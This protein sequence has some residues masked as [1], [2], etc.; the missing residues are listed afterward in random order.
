MS[1]RPLGSRSH[2]TKRK[3]A[4]AL[5]QRSSRLLLSRSKHLAAKWFRRKG[6]TV[7]GTGC[8]ARG[9][10]ASLWCPKPRCTPFGATWTRISLFSAAANTHSGASLPAMRPLPT[11][12]QSGVL[13]A[14]YLLV[15]ARR[16]CRRRARAA[17]G[18]GPATQRSGG[19][20]PR[21]G[22]HAPVLLGGAI[23]KPLAQNLLRQ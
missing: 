20:F 6:A 23:S 1:Q 13:P 14:Q 8:E 18:P 16:R 21:S 22:T 11:L 2:W 3:C 19:R 15:S 17:A 7:Y 10:G 12:R 9:G 5:A 4:P